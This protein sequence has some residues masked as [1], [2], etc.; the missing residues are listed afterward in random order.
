[1]P[2]PAN[3]LSSPHPASFAVSDALLIAPCLYALATE[4]LATWFALTETA[5]PF[6]GATSGPGRGYQAT[7]E[8]RDGR[9]YLIAIDGTLAGGRAGSLG[10][11]FP[12]FRQRV[13]AHWFSGQLRAV[14]P[15]RAVGSVVLEGIEIPVPPGPLSIDVEAGVVLAPAPA[16]Q[17]AQTAGLPSVVAA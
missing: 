9:L 8:I 1:M 13:F 10:D 4:P 6:A 11:L 14:S 16:G 15:R 17:P 3:P 5:S 12:E 2:P 7:W